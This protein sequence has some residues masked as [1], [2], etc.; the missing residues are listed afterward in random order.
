MNFIKLKTYTFDEV[1]FQVRRKFWSKLVMNIR[2]SKIYPWI[3][4]AYWKYT[5]RKK[6]FMT[7]CNHNYYSARP[8]PGAGIGHQLANWNAGFWFAN[9]FGLKFAHSPFSN[10]SWELFLGLGE[11]E[12][13]V[14]DLIKNGYSKVLLPLFD[15]FNKSEVEL[16]KNIILSYANQKVIFVAEQDQGYHDQFGVIDSF[17]EKFYNSPSREKDNLI[18]D[19]EHLNIAIHVRRGDIGTYSSNNNPNLLM[20]WQGN[21]YFVNVLQNVINNIKSNKDIAV[22]LFS[23]GDQI[24]FTEFNQFKNLHYCI[25]MDPKDS[26]LHMVF[27]DILIT[28]KSSF[29]YKPA[30]L[31]NGIKVC[32]KDFW[33]GY[34]YADDW[35]MADELGELSKGLPCINE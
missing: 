29:S 25:D 13:K 4:F 22:Y 16:Q 1:Y 21:D 27:A 9:Q 26:F 35:I 8:N 5:F 19:S 17:K 12:V 33:H 20:R 31:N 34:P 30:L 11:N 24:A 2:N 6:P 7:I 15:E 10:S 3:Y 23:Q 18:F 28:S 32:P 14:N